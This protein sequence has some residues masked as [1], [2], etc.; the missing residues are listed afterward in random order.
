MSNAFRIHIFDPAFTILQILSYQS[1]GYLTLS[2]AVIL[3]ETLA[4]SVITLDH[5][6]NWRSIRLDAVLGWFLSFAFLFNSCLCSIHLLHIVQRTRQCADFAI[7][8]YFFH[9]LITVIYSGSFP[10]SF[11]WWL[12]MIL[13]MGLSAVGGEHLCYQK[14]LQ[15]IMVGG[16]MTASGL[17]RKASTRNAGDEIELQRLTISD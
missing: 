7:T 6:F 5:V 10:W 16:N 8:F 12:V 13:C 17:R 15:P 9:I 4:G 14:E 1:A 11:G 3:V 2:I